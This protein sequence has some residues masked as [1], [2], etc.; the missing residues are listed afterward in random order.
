MNDLDGSFGGG[1]PGDIIVYNN[2]LMANNPNCRDTGQI[3]N[4]LVCSN[5]KNWVGLF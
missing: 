3:K 4:G 1:Q 2:T 5:T